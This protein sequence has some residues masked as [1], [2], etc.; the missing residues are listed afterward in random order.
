MAI[1]L[2]LRRTGDM[3]SSGNSSLNGEW[4]RWDVGTRGQGSRLG[5]HL[6]LRTEVRLGQG[7]GSSPV[8]GLD[9]G[10]YPEKNKE[11]SSSSISRVS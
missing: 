4:G 10:S 1:A 9:G 2:G 7:G 11:T 6:R 8:S 5:I 3:C